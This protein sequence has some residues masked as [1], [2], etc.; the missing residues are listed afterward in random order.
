MKRKHSLHVLAGALALLGQA[1]FALPSDIAAHTYV[2]TTI[3]QGF[4]RHEEAQQGADFISGS[5]GYESSVGTASANLSTG[6][7]KVLTSIQGTDTRESASGNSYAEAVDFLTFDSDATVSFDLGIDGS[8]SVTQAGDWALF[9]GSARFFDVTALANV[10]ESDG[11]TL[12]QAVIS[13]EVEDASTRGQFEYLGANFTPRPEDP[14]FGF[15]AYISTNTTGVPLS[16]DM[17]LSGTL[18]VLAGHTYLVLLGSLAMAADGT[19]LGL[20]AADF[21]S[22]STFAFTN[23][24]GASFTSASGVF[25]GAAQA[26]VSAPATL[27]LLFAGLGLIGYSTSRRS[28]RLP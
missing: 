25:P 3:F 27:P 23:L 9:Q 26:A 13:N 15:D 11:H 20:A 18:D 5:V 24:G 16:I 12:T 17:I 28:I 4:G 1:A 14:D 22:T 19:E 7:T 10:F 21:D 2:E 8:L 6:E